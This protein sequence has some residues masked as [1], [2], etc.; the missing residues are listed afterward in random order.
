MS[1]Q[2]ILQPNGKWAIYSTVTEEIKAYDATEKDLIRYA[3]SEAKKRVVQEVR[4]YLDRVKHGRTNQFHLTWE[5]AI[6][7]TA[8]GC[9]DKVFIAALK[10]VGK[11]AGAK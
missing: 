1:I 7:K 6:N 10:S 2:Y 11:R 4:A 9:D 8:E 3:V 5:Q